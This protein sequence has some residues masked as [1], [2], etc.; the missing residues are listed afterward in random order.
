MR[1]DR[2]EAA[3]TVSKSTD[4]DRSLRFHFGIAALA[5][6]AFVVY[7]SL[8]PFDFASQPVAIAIERFRH[9][10]SFVHDVGDRADWMANLLLYAPL[11]FLISAAANESRPRRQRLWRSVVVVVI[12]WLLATAVEFAQLFFPP[13]V[14]S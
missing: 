3:A 7:G 6:G 9:I 10:P 13:R 14:V 5:W 8:L 4:D 2:A 1:R 11:T 12:G